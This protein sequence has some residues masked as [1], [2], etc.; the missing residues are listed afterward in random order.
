MSA[1]A[2]PSRDI[3]VNDNMGSCPTVPFRCALV[4]FHKLTKCTMKARVKRTTTHV[5]STVVHARDAHYYYC[6]HNAFHARL[7]LQYCSCTVVACS[8]T[9]CLTLEWVVCFQRIFCFQFLVAHLRCILH[10]TDGT[11]QLCC[12]Q[13]CATASYYS[14]HASAISYQ[15]YK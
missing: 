15:L 14:S 5:V 13:G 12:M 9:W 1:C 10:H 6:C 3:T 8:I 7:I 4:P 2:E 11:V